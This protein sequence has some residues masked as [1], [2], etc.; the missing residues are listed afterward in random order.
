MTQPP[1]S[2]PEESDADKTTVFRPGDHGFAS[3]APFAGQS[4]PPPG[5]GP[6]Y[7]DQPPAG[8]PPPFGGGAASQGGYGQPGYAAGGQPGYGQPGYGQPAGY[9][10]AQSPYGGER[11]GPAYSYGITAAIV[12][13]I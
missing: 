10:S 2:T 1:P 3:S 9:G 12:A 13:I 8:S 6:S 11:R 4:S 5:Q 7:A